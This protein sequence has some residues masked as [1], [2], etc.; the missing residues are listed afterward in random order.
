M[1]AGSSSQPT[2]KS[3][4]NEND[5]TQFLLHEYDHISKSILDNEQFGEK[6]Y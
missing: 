3:D 4:N 6:R 1:Y 2:Q 5:S